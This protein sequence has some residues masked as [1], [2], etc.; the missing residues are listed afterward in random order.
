MDERV[1]DFLAHHGVKGMKWGKRKHTESRKEYKAR[2]KQELANYHQKKANSIL[3]EAMKRGD[4]VL[5][6]TKYGG[7]TYGSI[8]TGR[9]FVKSMSQSRAFDVRVTE[10]YAIKNGSGPYETAGLYPKFQKS[11]RR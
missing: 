2:S 6:A 7:D 9:D 11:E 4:N 3:S 8:V 5:I 10:I 1:D